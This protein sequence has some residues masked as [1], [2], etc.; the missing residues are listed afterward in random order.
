MVH[1][2]LLHG[3]NIIDHDGNIY[4][5]ENISIK[6]GLISSIGKSTFNADIT[7][8][9]QGKYI[10]PS[11]VNLHTHSP[12]NIFKGIAED[13]DIDTWFNDI[14]W[15]YESK[16]NSEDIYHSSRLAIAEMLNYG[17]SAYA[18]HYFF[19]ESI[20]NAAEDSGIKLDMAPTLFSLG[21]G[22]EKSL[23][24]TMELLNKYRDRENVKISLGPHSAYTCT[25]EDLCIVGEY[26]QKYNMKIHIHVSET[27]EQVDA[28]LKE[29]GITPIEVLHRTGCLRGNTIIAHGLYITEGDIKFI[30][31]TTNF[32]LSPK[33]YLKLSMGLGD[34]LKYKDIVNISIGTDGAASSNSLNPLEQTRILG[35]IGKH[36]FNDATEFDVKTLWSYLM[37][38][39]EALEFNSGR[40]Q[41][42]YSADLIIWDLNTYNTEINNNILASVI[43]SSDSSNIESIIVSGK[44]IKKNGKITA[45]L[46]NSINYCKERIESLIAEG[47][48]I[49]NLRF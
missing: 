42:G 43:Y 7:Y 24:D 34:I 47:G 16:L 18:D 9:C 23:Q 44:L 33:T 6:D 27:K 28:S 1:S 15:P 26:A 4:K 40:I 30:N 14:I 29:K 3:G 13:V 39:H 11:F 8:N 35:L 17:V 31:N 49:T 22:F 10:S 48:G 2:I 45:D 20:I 5:N 12:M 36:M 21:G 38:G 25:Y 37:K 41:E 19:P 32:V 46:S